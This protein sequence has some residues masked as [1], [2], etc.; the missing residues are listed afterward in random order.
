[1]T[2]DCPLMLTAF[3]QPNHYVPIKDLKIQHSK[4]VFFSS[5]AVLLYHVI[6]GTLYS[7]GM[8]SGYLHNLEE[9][10]R[11]RLTAS[12]SGSTGTSTC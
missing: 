2:L 11:E 8:H 7:K 3:N 1:M 10:D 6:H 9:Q 12:F 5:T 4:T